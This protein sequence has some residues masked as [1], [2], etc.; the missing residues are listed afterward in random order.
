MGNTA[1]QELRDSAV[2]KQPVIPK[3][4]SA[5]ETDA[6]A[7]ASRR[8]TLLLC[9]KGLQDQGKNIHAANLVLRIFYNQ[10]DPDERSLAEVVI[11]LRKET[12]HTIVRSSQVAE[13]IQA[14]WVIPLATTLHNDPDATNL[15]YVY[16]KFQASTLS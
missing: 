16:R 1:L 7:V 2:S 14:Q 12:Q 9:L 11:C 15:E 6:N 5:G 4:G 8:S 13:D 10:L 3:N